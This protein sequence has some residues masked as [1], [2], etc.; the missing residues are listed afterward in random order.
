[1]QKSITGF[2]LS[3][4][5]STGDARAIPDLE[6]YTQS[7]DERLVKEAREA[8]AVLRKRQSRMSKETENRN[9]EQRAEG[10]AVNRAP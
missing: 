6:E 9:G 2:V 4:L 3:A 7:D 1:M 8:L 10:D 5:G